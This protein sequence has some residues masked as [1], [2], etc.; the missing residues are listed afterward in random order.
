MLVNK[1]DQSHL[2]YKKQEEQEMR[3]THS[4]PYGGGGLPDRDPPL[5][6][7]FPLNRVPPGGTWEYEANW[8]HE[9]RL[10]CVINET[11]GSFQK[12]SSK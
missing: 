8:V 11:N 3:T 5:Y 6:R 4:S 7:D 2:F 1:Y 10:G 9:T 12:A